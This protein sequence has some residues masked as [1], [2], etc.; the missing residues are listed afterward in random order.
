ME[1]KKN[2][3][4]SIF[5]RKTKTNE[6]IITNKNCKNVLLTTLYFYHK[7]KLYETHRKIPGG[8]T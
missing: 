6:K 4:G 3:G 8:E 5:S 1:R 7:T 2:F